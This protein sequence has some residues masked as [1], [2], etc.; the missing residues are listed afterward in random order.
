MRLYPVRFRVG[1]DSTDSYYVLL[2]FYWVLLDLLDRLHV[3]LGAAVHRC[4]SPHVRAFSSLIISSSNCMTG[5]VL[6][7]PRIKI[8]P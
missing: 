3:L 1:R 5:H 4:R 8:L 2:T 7:H 6:W